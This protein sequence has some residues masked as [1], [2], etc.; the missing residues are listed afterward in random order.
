MVLAQA[1]QPIARLASS[2]GDGGFPWLSV[3]T[4]VPLAGAAVAAFLPGRALNLHRL[5]ALAVTIVTF[6]FSLGMLASFDGGRAGFQLVD[7]AVWVK[8]LNFNYLLG[9]DGISLFL[10]LLT[11]FLMP[12]AVLVSWRIDRAVKSYMIAFLILETA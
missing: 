6:G 7:R 12:A 1:V 4:F 5:W 9:V 8:S 11:T 3:V 10:V 2:G